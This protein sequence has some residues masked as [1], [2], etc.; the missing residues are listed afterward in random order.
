MHLKNVQEIKIST[1]VQQHV[2]PPSVWSKPQLYK[3]NV[4]VS[5]SHD[6]NKVGISVY[7]EQGP[8]VLAETEW[9]EPLTKVD[10]GEALGNYYQYCIRLMICN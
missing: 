7:D 8:C 2:R 9:I 6:H 1:T 5:F 3:F 10:I 4:D